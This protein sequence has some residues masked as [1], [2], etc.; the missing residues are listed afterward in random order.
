MAPAAI[1]GTGS[2]NS[3]VGLVDWMCEA[4]GR[5]WWSV[6][7]EER[8][9]CISALLGL[10]TPHLMRCIGKDDSFIVGQQPL[11]LLIDQRSK[12]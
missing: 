2:R 7:G 5:A 10:I 12:R 8:K 4:R 3:G 1:L 6:F 9:S 11:K